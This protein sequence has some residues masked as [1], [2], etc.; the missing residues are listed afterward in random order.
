MP[1]RFASFTWIWITLVCIAG[2]QHPE[3][4]PTPASSEN[5]CLSDPIQLT[6]NF[7]QAGEAYF[8]PDM[9][10]IIFQ[11]MT[12]PDQ[13]Y[14]MYVAPLKWDRDR[15]TGIGKPIR[16]TREGSWNSC[17][18]FSPDCNSVIFSS[19]RDPYAFQPTGPR[20]ASR[21]TTAPTTGASPPRQGGY[22]WTMPELTEIYRAD[23]WHGAVAAL[24]PDQGTDLAKHP[25]THNNAYD[26]E[27]GYSPDGQW[28]VYCSKA[29]GDAEIWAMRADGTKPVQLTHN[30]G[31]DGGPFFSPDGRRICY[32]SDRRGNDLLQVFV[33]DLSFDSAGDITGIRNER[34]LTRDQPV[35]D[36]R[37]V[38]FGSGI[39]WGPFWHPDNHHLIWAT[40]AHAMS[41]FELYLMRDDGSH[42]TRVTFTNGPDLLPAFSPDGKWLMWT[43][44]RGPEK[45]SQIW[46]ARF[47]LPK[48]S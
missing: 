17:G 3:F 18:Y 39:N 27:C 25:L 44:R 40:S 20:A 28:I 48:G 26:A 30:P 7:E 37:P 19:T 12:R 2:C 38:N 6:H 16:I 24:A 14:V 13:W 33:A 15:I 9:K 4:N 36:G 35:A 10:W 41:N 23:G 21:P 47:T 8:S 43:T 45:T 31:Y 34:Q 32:R 11:A 29:T 5:D 1:S 22:R 42:K 46:V